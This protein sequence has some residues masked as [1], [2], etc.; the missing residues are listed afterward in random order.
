MSDEDAGRPG[1]SKAD[2]ELNR[3]IDELAERTSLGDGAPVPAIATVALNEH[4]VLT[5]YNP[6]GTTAPLA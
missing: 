1:L 2:V 4:G 6:D 3:S 5:V